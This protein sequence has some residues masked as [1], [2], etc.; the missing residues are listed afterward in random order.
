MSAA[1]V[2]VLRDAAGGVVGASAYHNW[3]AVEE[4]IKQG[5][6]K[7]EGVWTDL[8]DF[9]AQIMRES[10]DGRSPSTFNGYTLTLESLETRSARAVPEVLGASLQEE[11]DAID[12]IFY[13]DAPPDH[14]ALNVDRTTWPALRSILTAG[15]AAKHELRATALQTALDALTGEGK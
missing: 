12:E 8:C 6:N 9:S 3:L 4:A 1:A 15:L 11:I 10:T 14:T 13:A 7:T 5:R 2:W